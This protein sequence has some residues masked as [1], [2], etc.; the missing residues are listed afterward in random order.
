MTEQYTS[1][2]RTTM[3]PTIE[4]FTKNLDFILSHFQGSCLWPRRISTKTTD[5]R[6]ILVYSKEEALARYR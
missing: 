2:T 3:I 5:N 1:T 6:Q 4:E